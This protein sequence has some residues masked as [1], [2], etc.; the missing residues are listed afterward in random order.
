[1]NSQDQKKLKKF[2]LVQSRSND[3]QIGVIISDPF[4]ANFF[5]DC[6]ASQAAE[7]PFDITDPNSYCMEVEMVLVYVFAPD[8][9][10]PKA[11]GLHS[12]EPA[13]SQYLDGYIPFDHATGKLREVLSLKKFAEDLWK[14]GPHSQA[15]TNSEKLLV[16][17]GRVY[18]EIM[19]GVQL[20]RRDLEDP[21]DCNIQPVNPGFLIIQNHVKQRF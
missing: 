7:I 11:V 3:I 1:M 10:G 5:N 4:T 20:H 13:K 16:G 12:L 2:D 14:K 15:P 6:V 18:E 9:T 19:P 17:Q 8:F 21:N